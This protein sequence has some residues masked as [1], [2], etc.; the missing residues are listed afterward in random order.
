MLGSRSIFVFRIRQED[1]RFIRFCLAIYITAHGVTTWSATKYVKMCELSLQKNSVFLFWAENVFDTKGRCASTVWRN[2]LKGC[3][4]MQQAAM[5]QTVQM[6]LWENPG[7]DPNVSNTIELW[8]IA[9]RYVYYTDKEVQGVGNYLKTIDRE[10]CHAGKTYKLTLNPARI[11]R[12]DGT[13]VEAYPGERE[14]IIEE[15]IRKLAVERGRLRLQGENVVMLFSLNEI[16]KELDRTKHSA[17]HHEIKE[18]LKI[19]Q[20]ANVEIVQQTGDGEKSETRLIRGSAFP[21]IGFHEK[22]NSGDNSITF[23]QFNWMVATALKHLE[24]RP[25]NYETMMRLKTM[26]RWLFKKMY[27][28]TYYP[29]EGSSIGSDGSVYVFHATEI[30]RDCGMSQWK[31]W[32]DA[33]NAITTAVQSLEKEGVVVNLEVEPVLEGRKKVDTIYTMRA[34]PTFIEQAKRGGIIH[35]GIIEEF[36]EFTGASS[37]KDFQVISDTKADSIRRTREKRVRQQAV[38]TMLERSEKE[39]TLVS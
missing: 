13:D 7:V 34:S 2:D 22:G 38:S 1:G 39:D 35:E 33:M 27:H 25:I 36:K 26:A 32:R 37:P 10:F 31:R 24:F 28:E 6:T 5:K 9:P 23:V 19:L 30:A 12:E 8:D 29:S 18:S 14:H 4:D 3:S 15:V 20:G 21:Q 16:R 11:R 17:R